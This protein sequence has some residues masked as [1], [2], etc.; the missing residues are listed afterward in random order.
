M[1]FRGYNTLKSE[2]AYTAEYF[3]ILSLYLYFSI[4]LLKGSIVMKILDA[5]EPKKVFYYFEEITK[6]PRGSGNEK[7]I[8]D[9]LLDFGKSLGFES[10]QDSAL[11]VIIKK[12]ASK[13]YESA[14]TVIIQGHMD[15]VCEKNKN[16][17]HDFEKDPLKLRIDGDNIYAAGTTLGGD[18]GIA[19]A[20]A[21]ALLESKDIAHPP[22]E[23]LI[24]TDEETGMT[25]AMAVD[26]SNIKGKILLNI[27]SE[28]EGKLLVSCAGGAKVNVFSEIE[29][30]DSNKE[31]KAF[32]ISIG[33]LKGGHSGMEID[34]GRGNSN[35]LM[36]RILMDLLE[37]IKFD[38]V[39]L[40]G[41]AKDNA[42]P[43]ETDAEVVVSDKDAD[44]LMERIEIFNKTFRDEL[45]VQDADVKVSVMEMEYVPGK[46]F[47]KESAKRA[48]K[49]LYLMPNG[50]QTMS[51]NIKGL[52]ES[53]LNLGVVK[54][55][56]NEVCFSLAV[57][58]SVASL[59]EEIINHIKTLSEMFGA[60]ADIKGSYPEWQYRE[61]SPIRDLCVKTYQE[62]YGEM[63]EIIA[64]HAGLECGLFM[65]KLG[66]DVDMV[67]FG[68]NMYD[69]HT[70]DEHMSISS[71]K[72]FWEY[73]IKVL[74][75]IK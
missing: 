6:I 13:G 29:W 35:K 9:Y 45:R 25:G 68:P 51:M 31:G 59:K 52:V 21:L 71:V 53:S 54:T 38:L 43:R 74:G 64:I 58:S 5:I 11:N 20:Y 73:L 22:L 69:I 16:T 65:E 14:P 26:S 3:R 70:P 27:D 18:D 12:P 72:R 4:F 44:L 37:N 36:G 7:E 19:V 63:P 2:N 55:Y 57:R 8:S 30:S 33:G 60:K 75:E 34:K 48:I 28:E 46:V 61:V 40:N 67:S 66:K 41:G 10:I 23:V 39:N 17:V 1:L 62:M 50:I 24:T 56:E 47:S 42:I 32:K 15:M 49:L